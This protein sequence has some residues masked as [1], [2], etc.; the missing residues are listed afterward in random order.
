MKFT[1]SRAKPTSQFWNGQKSLPDEI[2]VMSFTSKAA[3]FELL[4]I[5]CLLHGFVNAFDI[6]TGSEP[7]TEKDKDINAVLTA[8]QLYL[9]P[10]MPLS[11]YSGTEKRNTLAIGSKITP[12][13]PIKN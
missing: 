1:L 5:I 9:H 8:F 6:L 2:N 13:D 12:I 7:G 3:E 4:S 10:K 11:Q